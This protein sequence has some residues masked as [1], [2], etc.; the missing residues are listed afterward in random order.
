MRRVKVFLLVREKKNLRATT[1]K[2]S[3]HFSQKHEPQSQLL[4][5]R[6][7]QRSAEVRDRRLGVLFVLSC[8]IFT[9]C[10]GLLSGVSPQA[11]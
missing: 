8:M 10:T 5:F 2:I 9:R 6:N 3:R 7:C 11:V 4:W 1:E